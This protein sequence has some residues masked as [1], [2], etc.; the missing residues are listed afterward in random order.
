MKNEVIHKH[1]I[2]LVGLSLRTNN[3]NEMNP[4]TAKI[5]DLAGLYWVQNIAAQI[6]NRINPD[7]TLAV[8]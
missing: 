8:R 1:E 3:K 2:K 4:L 6:S 5:G 7:V